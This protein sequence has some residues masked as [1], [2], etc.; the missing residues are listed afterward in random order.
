MLDQ[1]LVRTADNWI[2]GPY[3]VDQICQMIQE[4][5]L[6]L[7]DEICLANQYW[8][9]LHEREEVKQFLGIEVPKAHR[10]VDDEVT[11]TETVMEDGPTD[12]GISGFLEHASVEGFGESF[13]K[14]TGGE[15]LGENT[16]ENTAV[17]HTAALK[18][19]K[20]KAASSSSLKSSSSSRSTS[21]RQNTS[22]RKAASASGAAPEM[23]RSRLTASAQAFHQV[24]IVGQID[25]TSFW[26][27][28]AWVLVASSTLLIGGMVWLLRR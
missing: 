6:T 1:W 7:Q 12:P 19:L 2:A 16:S 25:K 13:G 14:G 28:L 17:I 11:E 5:K 20:S 18:N 23:S 4:G 27:G 15:S 21:K 22:A 3:P 24:E 9:Y 10:G 26:R 8:V